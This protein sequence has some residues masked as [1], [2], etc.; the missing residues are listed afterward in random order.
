MAVLLLTPDKNWSLGGTVTTSGGSTDSDYTDDWLTDGNTGRVVK[1]AGTSV[2]WTVAASSGIVNGVVLANSNISVAATL[3]GSVSG[4]IPAAVDGGTGIRLN[5]FLAITPVLTATTL[6]VAIASNGANV[7]LGQILAGDFLTLAPGPLADETNISFRDFR[8]PRARSILPYDKGQEAR[9]VSTA[10]ICTTSVR[11]ALIAGWRAQRA[12]SR[13]SVLVL[14]SAVSD[15][16][17]GQLL[18]LEFKQAG[19]ADGRAAWKVSFD[20]EED[21]RD[22]WT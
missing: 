21:I 6:S 17:V 13:P 11:D 18:N 9:D 8:T 12:G 19:P 14:D 5:A 20:F 1:A 4:T 7:A 22:R 16:M 2:T 3:G 15:A 10:M